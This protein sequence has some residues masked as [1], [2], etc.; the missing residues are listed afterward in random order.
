MALKGAARYQFFHG[1]STREQA[2]VRILKDLIIE[3]FTATGTHCGEQHQCPNMV[4]LKQFV[5]QSRLLLG[6]K[7]PPPP[8]DDKP[9]C[10]SDSLA[11]VRLMATHFLFDQ[12]TPPG[13]WFAIDD[14]QKAVYAATNMAPL[15]LGPKKNTLN[16]DW[17]L[18]CLNFFRYYM[19]TP[20]ASLMCEAMDDLDES[21]KPSAWREPLKSGSYPLSSHW[22]GTYAFLDHHDLAR[23]RRYTNSKQ[24]YDRIFTDLNVD[25]GKIQVGA[26]Y[27]SRGLC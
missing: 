12:V 19:T 17:V 27:H 2:V 13:S 14:A 26:K 25:E 4:R 9:A 10:V 15:Y 1:H 6:G 3:S 21:Q 22:K 7:R 5:M 16:M 24:D 18:Q 11:A 8:I 23:F 20:D